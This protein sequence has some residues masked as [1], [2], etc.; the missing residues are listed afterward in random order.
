MAINL[1]SEFMKRMFLMLSFVAGIS[2]A[3]NAQFFKKSPEQRANHITRVLQKRLK[4]SEDQSVKVKSAFLTQATRIDSLRNN[5]S[6]D[7]K[8]NRRAAKLILLGTQKNVIAVL[9]YD[10]QREFIRWEK[11]RWE[12]FI[13]RRAQNMDPK[14]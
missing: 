12:M 4:L 14:G 9:N 1:E 7:R 10:Q 3:A 8:T 6:P 2:M 5:L 13:Q 11:K